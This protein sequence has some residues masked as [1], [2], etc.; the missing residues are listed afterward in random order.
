AGLEETG[1]A[2][3]KLIDSIAILTVQTTM[4]SVTGAIEAVRGGEE[5]RGFAVVANDIRDLARQSAAGA[6]RIKDI[7]RD[8]QRQAA[9]VR[10]ELA[11][12]V[13]AG[14]AEAARAQA[15]DGRLG[16]LERDQEAVVA[17]AVEISEGAQS[18]LA[19]SRQVAT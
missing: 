17:G 9:A 10:A 14:E 6:D 2:M 11:S 4:L 12:V 16:A 5:G 18:I 1:R 15:I 3:E 13:A 8:L 7:V 19:A